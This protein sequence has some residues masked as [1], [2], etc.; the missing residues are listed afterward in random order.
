MAEIV[1]FNINDIA[2]L[3]SGILSLALAVLI[4]RR[5]A[6]RIKKHFKIFLSLFFFLGTLNAID[7]I[8][9]WSVNINAAL[10]ALS[11]N[12]FFLGGF[13]F[14][15]QGPLLYGFTK[16][17]IFRHYELRRRDLWHLLPTILYPLYMYL[18]YFQFDENYKLQY[19]H[20]WSRVISNPY[21][22]M[23][24]WFQRFSVFYYS[25]ICTYILYQ[26]TRHLINTKFQLS[27]VDLHWL[28]L[29]IL[30]FLWINLWVVVGL[31][32]SR[33]T[34][35]DLGG[36]MGTMESYFRC[37]YVCVLV[38]YLLHHSK[39]FVDIQLEHTLNQVPEERDSQQKTIEQL[40]SYMDS[41][42]P[43]LDPHLTVERLAIRLDVSP[44]VLSSAINMQLKMNFFEVIGFYRIEESKRQLADAKLKHMTINE[45][46]K[47]CGF[48]SKSVFNLAFKK[49]TGVTPSYYR[50]QHRG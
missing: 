14:L 5:P 40:Q 45:V 26:Y 42:K 10:S 17:A 39:G 16:A 34:A 1:L 25:I 43:Y 48:N 32:I 30:G 49:S 47:N 7:T 9:Y 22:E 6:G 38:I 44:K 12:F 13:V 20:D 35:F 24:I 18:I 23:A 31:L 46:M 28:N 37:I 27:K 4:Y 50:Q 36:F 11:P 21:F 19:V 33:F 8:F 15:L 2:V 3:L 41:N 29:L